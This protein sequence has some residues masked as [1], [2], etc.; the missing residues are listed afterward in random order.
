MTTIRTFIFEQIA[1]V[2]GKLEAIP[3]GNGTM[4]DNTLIIFTSDFGEAHHAQTKEWPFV[5]IGDL[6]GR[7][8]AGRV[9]VYP[10]FRHQGHK[11]LNHLY[12]TLM[13][14]VGERPRTFGAPDIH[15]RDLDMTG[16]LNELL[17]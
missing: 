11:S 9:L 5:L 14:T 12:T 6:G 7:L 16:P 17:A 8:R 4:L 13:Y 15:L 2:M 3:E 10:P 1:S